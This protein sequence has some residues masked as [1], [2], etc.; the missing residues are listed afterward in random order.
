MRTL[1]IIIAF[2]SHMDDNIETFLSH[3]Q[4][5]II[6]IISE[7]ISSMYVSYDIYFNTFYNVFLLHIY[8]IP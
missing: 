5:I 1:E 6:L 8:I 4:L 2:S 3:L 7:D